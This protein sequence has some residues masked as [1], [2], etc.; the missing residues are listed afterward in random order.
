MLLKNT[1]RHVTSRLKA[2]IRTPCG[3]R[4]TVLVI[5]IHDCCVKIH[6]TI[7][8]ENGGILAGTHLAHI[9]QQAPAGP[10]RWGSSYSAT[11]TRDWP[12]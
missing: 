2:D 7:N 4:N 3:R 12:Q 6:L 10:A 1:S 9:R 5:M 11:E 8:E